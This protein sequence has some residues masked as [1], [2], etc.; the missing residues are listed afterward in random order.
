MERKTKQN[1]VFST[2][3]KQDK[4]KLIEQG[5][6]TVL[7]VCKM[8]DVSSVA[9]YKWKWK[10]G[11]AGKDER[12]VIEKQ[13][14]ATKTL[15]LMKEVAKLEQIIGKQQIE[16]LYKDA[17]IDLGSDLL[18]TDLKKKYNTPPSK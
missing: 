6:L 3:F 13:S 18:G 16:L 8:Y 1:R 14:E 2:A 7:Q 15:L 5:K 11:K 17:I 10:Y 9:V 4:V 12:I